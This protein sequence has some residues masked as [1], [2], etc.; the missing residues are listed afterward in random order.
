MSA[1]KLGRFAGLVFVL[2]ALFAGGVG[3]VDHNA[4]H[5]GAV[6]SAQ[7]AARPAQMLEVI[8]D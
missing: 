1:R 2:A 7:S 3:V 6:A 8:W 4:K 5:S